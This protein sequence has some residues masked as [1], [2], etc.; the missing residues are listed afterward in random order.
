VCGLAGM[1]RLFVNDFLQCFLLSRFR[2]VAANGVNK[3]AKAHD[4]LCIQ[5]PFRIDITP[6]GCYYCSKFAKKY[7]HPNGV[8]LQ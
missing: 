4:L 8:A 3:V 1:C 2:K 5:L 6:Q 7:N